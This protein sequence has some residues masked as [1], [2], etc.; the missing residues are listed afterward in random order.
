M[1]PNLP[2]YRQRLIS[3][4]GSLARQAAKQAARPMLLAALVGQVLVELVAIA[5]AALVGSV[6]QLQGWAAVAERMGC[7]QC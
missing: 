2:S 6:T 7:C 4:A 3:R 5:I 1:A